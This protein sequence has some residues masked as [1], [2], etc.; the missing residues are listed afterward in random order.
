VITG[1]DHVQLAM[2]RG[3][4]DQARLFYA[5]LLEMTEIGKPAALAARGGCWFTAGSAHLHLGIADSFIAARKAHPALLTTDLDALA[6][7]L[8]AAD[9]AIIRADSELERP[10]PAGRT[11]TRVRRFHTSDVFGNRI[12][13]HQC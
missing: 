13:F 12:E 2:P 9:Y 5:D 1:I 8:T 11:C 7:R 10:I 3:A 6:A 4:E